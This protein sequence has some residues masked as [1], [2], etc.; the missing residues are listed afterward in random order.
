VSGGLNDAARS[1]LTTA[2]AA[3]NNRYYGPVGKEAFSGWLT[4]M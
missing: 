1:M 4:A 2:L 3:V